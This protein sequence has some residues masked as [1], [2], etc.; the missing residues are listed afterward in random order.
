MKTCNIYYFL[1]W[2]EVK[3]IMEKLN[4][5]L[6]KFKK[7]IF[8]PYAIIFLFAVIIACI[9]SR[10]TLISGD[11]ELFASALSNKNIFS[12]LSERYLTWSGRLVVEFLLVNIIAQKII[13]WKILNTFFVTMLLVS[14][15]LYINDK[16]K[17]SRLEKI[18]LY[19]FG[20]FLFFILNTYVL[21]S[22]V[23][24]IT[25]SFNYLWTT[26][27]MLF[28]MVPFKRL[29]F[30]EKASKFM[31]I[32]SILTS[33][34]ACYFEQTAVVLL[35]YSTLC[36]IYVLFKKI[37]LNKII[38]LPYLS[39]IINSVILF[40]SPGNKIRFFA[41]V[42]HWYPGF[43][44]LSIFT[45]LYR[46][47]AWTLNH[48]VN[49]NQFLMFILVILLSY[50][51]YK[52]RSK[53]FTISLIPV[54]Y[55]GFRIISFE[56]TV[57]KIFAKEINI[58]QILDKYIYNILGQNIQSFVKYIP[59]LIICVIVFI[60]F[61]EIIFFL[62]DKLKSLNIV[63]L[64]VASILTPLTLSFSPTIYASGHRIFFT[65]DIILYLI[66]LFIYKETL[67]LKKSDNMLINIITIL[68]LSI[69]LI[70]GLNYLIILSGKVYY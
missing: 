26:V 22:S 31:Y 14:S 13:F 35:T 49:E 37:K 2:E 18:N 29:I 9:N 61:L 3:V 17:L 36:I 62:K 8:S 7:M 19:S 69:S 40:L 1:I 64:Y 4:S 52:N 68:F 27:A 42:E 20:M 55:F 5:Y 38:I 25:G 6:R 47:L 70:V 56:H 66:I 54:V 63:I 23:F 41:E 48:I 53:I 11:D 50:M 28:T 34:L 60:I 51:L 33:I 58:Q 45:K 46:G 39:I 15:I 67:K 16:S 59:I 65:G 43:D 24:W 30:E 10:I 21:S 44:Q 12:F 57:N 32:A